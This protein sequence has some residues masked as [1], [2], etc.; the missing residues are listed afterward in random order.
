[1]P[2][3]KLILVALA[4][5][6]ALIVGAVTGLHSRSNLAL[7]DARRGVGRVFGDSIPDLSDSERAQFDAGYQLFIKVWKLSEGQ[8][9]SQNGN[10]CVACHMEPMPG[11]S[12]T[13]SR[14]FV[15]M[16][17]RSS[18]I[19]GGHVFRR[20]VVNSSGEIRQ[21]IPLEHTSRKT[22][23][24]FGLGLLEAVQDKV[25]VANRTANL[26]WRGKTMP[27][28]DFVEKAM[29][30]ELGLETPRFHH[31]A[32]ARRPAS[33]TATQYPDVSAPQI[34]L[35][36]QFI[37][38]LGPPRPKSADYMSLP[39]A[40]LFEK[41]GCSTCHTP[42]LVTGDSEIQA[43]RHKAIFPFTDLRTHDMGLELSDCEDESP[44]HCSRFRTSPLW[45]LSSTGPPFLH[46]GRAE[47]LEQA[48]VAHGGDAQTSRNAYLTLSRSDK[49]LLREFLNSL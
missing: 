41:L 27:L 45:G 4:T 32:N 40:P 12:G 21:R 13:A 23:S 38:L 36:T 46:D 33:T 8:Q 15:L 35:M 19:A 30:V 6:L 28:S 37:R 44:P 7:E 39:G 26:G 18:D 3:Q 16:S 9:R 20:L 22:P 43:L 31:L 10:T 2:I 42:M 11:G 47:T 49:E 14:T 48:I 24:L 29:A 34:Q 25:P 17:S 5:S 1:M